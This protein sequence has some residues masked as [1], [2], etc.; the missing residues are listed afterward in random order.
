MEFK[1]GDRVTYPSSARVYR[2]ES[3]P[4]ISAGGTERYLLEILTG[5]DVGQHRFYESHSMIPASPQVN[6]QGRFIGHRCPLRVIREINPRYVVT[7]L[8]DLEQSPRWSQF[9]CVTREQFDTDWRP[10]A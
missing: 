4:W 9:S 5:D 10:E 2:V 1:K 6:D 3:G 8:V 7:E